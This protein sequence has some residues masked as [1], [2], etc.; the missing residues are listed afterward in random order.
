M[1]RVIRL[2]FAVYCLV[3]Y[4]LVFPFNDKRS[5]EIGMLP[6]K[7]FNDALLTEKKHWKWTFVKNLFDRYQNRNEAEQFLR[8]PLICHH[9]W[10]GSPLPKKNIEL[11]DSWIDKHPDWQFILW[12]DKPEN[13]RYGVQA[14][15]IK[16]LQE[17][18]MLGEKQIVFDIQYVT[19]NNQNMLQISKNLGQKS[20]ILRYE[21]LYMFGGLYVDT[22][23]ECLKP[24]DTLHY[25]FDFYTGIGYSGK[26]SLLNGL[27]GASVGNPILKCCIDDLRITCNSIVGII[28]STGPKYFSRC[29]FD[30]LQKGYDGRVVAFP[31]TYFYPWPSYARNETERPLIEKWFCPESFAVHHWHCSWM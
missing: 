31:T 27:I 30:M 19:L 10:L 6:N 26:F 23:F 9:I 3:L 25:H 29:F 21:I 13:Y 5:F 14:R 22:D 11:R 16:E 2:F 4:F 1:D 24:F 20:D 8:I 12:T 7:N 18:L 17:L 28:N 15:S